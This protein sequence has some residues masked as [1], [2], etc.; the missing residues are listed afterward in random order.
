MGADGTVDGL[1]VT[2]DGLPVTGDGLPGGVESELGSEDPFVKYHIV[3]EITINITTAT[4][5]ITGF[6]YN[7]PRNKRCSGG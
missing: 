2:G 6:I 3:T 5:I 1:P 7:I 4:P